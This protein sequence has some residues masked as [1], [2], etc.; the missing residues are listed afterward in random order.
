MLEATLKGN[1]CMEKSVIMGRAKT[2]VMETIIKACD[3]SIL[4]QKYAQYFGFTENLLNK[5]VIKD[6]T[7]RETIK[8]WYN[9]YQIGD[10]L[11][12]NPFSIAKFF[13]HLRI[14]SYWVDR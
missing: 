2:V 14:T 4:H 8:R 6:V 9:G 1:K 3:Y 11:L 7:M 10:F 5:A 13:E 12:Y